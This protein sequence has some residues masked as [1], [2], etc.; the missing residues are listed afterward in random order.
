MLQWGRKALRGTR[1]RC[2][3][4]EGRQRQAHGAAE[5]MQGQ[6]TGGGGFC[7]R[8]MDSGLYPELWHLKE[9]SDSK[10]IQ[11]HETKTQNPQ[12]APS[13]T[14]ITSRSKP[15]ERVAGLASKGHNKTPLS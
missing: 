2:G 15:W 13:Y 7:P 8:K 10:S 4:I 5:E 12:A 9:L 3:E 1:N 11:T 14:P 6:Q